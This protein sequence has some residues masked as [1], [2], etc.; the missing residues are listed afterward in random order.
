MQRVQVND[1]KDNIGKEVNLK[2]WAQVVRDQKKIQFIVFRDV[3]GV[4]QLVVFNNE[5]VSETVRGL[6]QESV[7]SVNG[8]VKE[9]KQAPGGFEVEVKDIKVLSKADPELPIPV[10]EKNENETEI[11]KRLDWRWVDLRKEKNTLAYKIWT[12]LENG[13]R[14]YWSNNKYIQIHSPKFMD[15]PS[16][17]G[18]EVFKVNYFEDHAYLAQSPQFYKQ[19]AMAS[20][21]EKVF[22]I[23]SVFRAEPS[24]TSRHAT[25]FTGYDFEISFIESEE[26]VMKEAEE[27]LSSALALVEKMYGKDIERV[28]GSKL[29]VP[30]KPFPKVTM[31]EAKDLLKPFKIDSEKQDDLNQTEEVKLSEI[32]KE[33]YNHDFVFV[34]DYPTSARP[35][36]HMRKDKETTRSADLLFKGIEIITCAQRE[37]NYETLVAQAKE[38][39]LKPESIKNYLNFFKYGC[40]PHG[41]AGI[42]PE[43]ILMK[44]CG[45]TN[46][47]EAQFIY[48]GVKRLTP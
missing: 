48:R 1:L 36:Y 25:E 39:G 15:A 27:V 14:D 31:Q 24:F 34:T 2:G 10:V 11:D 12:T 30:K 47:R 17:S 28:Y 4:V 26:D 9:E 37:H 33:K 18:A 32:I 43:R 8:L 6:S 40:P 21:F 20:G 3:T 22:E 44:I 45:F 23:G 7:I 35:F 19:M 5:K 46:I 29:I 38:K 41:G 13:F 16:E 42:G